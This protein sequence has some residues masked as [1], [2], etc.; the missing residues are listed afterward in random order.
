MLVEVPVHY[1][2]P[3]ASRRTVGGHDERDGAGSVVGVDGLSTVE[4]PMV[5]GE[6]MV[7]VESFVKVPVSPRICIRDA[8]GVP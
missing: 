1:L 6:S 7:T 5:T 2:A 4:P 8:P 3:G